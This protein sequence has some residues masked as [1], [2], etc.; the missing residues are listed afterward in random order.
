M[1]L[2]QSEGT[3]GPGKGNTFGAKRFVGQQGQ[4]SLDGLASLQTVWDQIH[5][6]YKESLYPSC[7]GVF[8]GPSQTITLWLSAVTDGEHMGTQAISSFGWW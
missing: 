6:D 7:D 2:E 1:H 8:C 4:F 5:T 3:A